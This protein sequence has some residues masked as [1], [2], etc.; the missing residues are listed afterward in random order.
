M[1]VPNPH[2]RF[3]YQDY[4]ALPESMEKRYELL[5]GALLMVPAPSTTHQRISRNLEYQLIE[6]CNQFEFG[7]VLYAPVDVVLGKGDERE[8]VQPDIILVAR[9][10]L[11]IITEQEISGA[12][13]LVVEIISPGTEDRDRSYKMVLYA[14][15]GV[16]EYWIVDPK[17][18]CIEIYVPDR[19]GF[20]QQAIYSDDGALVSPLLRSFHLVPESIFPG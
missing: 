10:R 5:G 20:V 15:Y 3:R 16:R 6:F 9:E 17:K 8:V 13:D 4:K 18:R 7:E 19:T 11:A 14:R 2:I 1:N 12:P